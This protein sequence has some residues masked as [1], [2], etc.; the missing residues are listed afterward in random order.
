MP[1]PRVDLYL[2]NI[3]HG[4]NKGD[5]GPAEEAFKRLLDADQTFK[6]AAEAKLVSLTKSILQRDHV[7]R[8]YHDI[9]TR[10]LAP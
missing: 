6:T 4:I 1:D 8:V 3:Y 7:S 10:M 2:G 5:A 9:L